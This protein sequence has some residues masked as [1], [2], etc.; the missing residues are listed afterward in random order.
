LSDCEVSI[1]K[2]IDEPMDFNN[3]LE[4][5][6]IGLKKRLSQQSGASGCHLTTNQSITTYID[7]LEEMA[8]CAQ[9]YATAAR[10]TIDLYFTVMVRSI[11]KCCS[12]DLE[13]KG[14]P[15][16]LSGTRGKLTTDKGLFKHTLAEMF[17]VNVDDVPAIYVH[18]CDGTKETYEE[19]MT[20]EALVNIVLKKFSLR[21]VPVRIM[22]AD[23]NNLRNIM[24]Y[25]AATIP[26]I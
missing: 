25:Q 5:V 6:P 9:D 23:V 15:I 26:E 19:T 17:I 14:P 10:S 7:Q 1:K 4:F 8:D 3:K 12:I 13:I 22:H 20:L 16:D 21:H 11:N 18:F 2:R 24:P